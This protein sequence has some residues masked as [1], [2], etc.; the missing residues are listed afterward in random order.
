MNLPDYV[1]VTEA[2]LRMNGLAVVD[3]SGKELTPSAASPPPPPRRVVTYEDALAPEVGRENAQ[4]ISS[5]MGQ[6]RG[7]KR[8]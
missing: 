6:L 2:Y 7:V 3:Q 5:L 8:G 1:S 4:A